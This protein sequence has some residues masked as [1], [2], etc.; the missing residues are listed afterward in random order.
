MITHLRENFPKQR[1]KVSEMDNF[2]SER[3]CDNVKL[4]EY[5]EVLNTIR[6]INR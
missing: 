4:R 5:R 6:N 1:A 2:S 3:E